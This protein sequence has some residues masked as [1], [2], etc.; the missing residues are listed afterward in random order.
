MTGWLDAMRV[1]SNIVIYA[2][3]SSLHY[4]VQPGIASFV[5]VYME[6]H[7]V[8]HYYATKYPSEF[9]FGHPFQQS[10]FLEL[11]QACIV[12]ACSLIVWYNQLPMRM[13][14][15]PTFPQ[16]RE[17]WRAALTLLRYFCSQQVCIFNGRN[18]FIALSDA[19]QKRSSLGSTPR[20]AATAGSRARSRPW[21]HAILL[22]GSSDDAPPG[23]WRPRSRKRWRSHAE[24]DVSLRNCSGAGA[25]LRKSG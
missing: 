18:I 4:A 1:E 14:S 19:A 12:W 7:K 23:H 8:P 15:A 2:M 21:R 22:A 10:V 5:M 25:K 16:F 20:P 9:P 24:F 11:H 6:T 13:A 3:V 17:C